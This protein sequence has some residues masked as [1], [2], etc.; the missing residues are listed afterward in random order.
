MS[1]DY[2]PHLL[3]SQ[4]LLRDLIENIDAF[5]I[6]RL[7][8]HAPVID[9]I[10]LEENPWGQEEVMGLKKWVE[11]V[12]HHG[13]ILE[14]MIRSGIPPKEDPLPT[15][16]GL[17][18][19]WKIIVTSKP[20]TV[21]VRM[22][23]GG[24]K[25]IQAGNK[26]SNSQRSG[27]STPTSVKDGGGQNG[28]MKTA[29]KEKEVWVDV[30]ADGG[31]EWIRIYSKK[32]SHLLAEF[33]EADSYINSDY[34]SD[35]EE[36]EEA[37]EDHLAGGKQVTGRPHSEASSN[38]LLDMARDLARAAS[39]V[40]RIPGAEMPR[41]T[42]RLTRIPETPLELYDGSPNQPSPSS[43]GGE[44]GEWPDSRIPETF[45][46]VRALGVN[47]LFGDLSDIPLSSPI[48]KGHPVPEQA[49]PSLKINLDITTLMGLCSDVLHHPLPADRREAARRSLRPVD[50]LLVS[51][52]GQVGSRGRDGT[53][54]GK[55]KG[56]KEDEREMGEEDE[57]L[58]GQS[59]N[60][61]E[62]FRCI[63]E[64]MERPFIEEFDTVLRTAWKDQER[65][66]RNHKSQ[67]PRPR[68]DLYGQDKQSLPEAISQLDIGKT[69]DHA[70]AN[71]TKTP[72]VEFWTTR[73]AAQYTYEALSSG[74][75]H[76][77]GAE[78]RRMRRM[79]GLEQGDFFE[80]SRYEGKA[81]V[82]EGF[83]LRIFDTER[84][85]PG[86]IIEDKTR[87]SEGSSD[88]RAQAGGREDGS[89][90]NGGE[91]DKTGFH[92]TLAAITQ[93]FLEQYYAS[94]AAN[95]ST[96]AAP[97]PNFLQPKKIPTPPVAKI[98]LPFPVVSLHSLHRGAREGMTTIM[99]G[100]ATLK[101]VWGQTRWRVRGWERGWYNL[102][103]EDDEDSHNE[104]AKGSQRRVW[105]KG[106]TAVMIFPYRVFGEGKRVRFE[107][108]DYSYPTTA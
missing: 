31:R 23:M 63:L 80:G 65:R 51:N 78:Q 71:Q 6:D 1:Q 48:F 83:K 106:P 64:E 9:R 105:E 35:T 95:S 20:P 59:Q 18:T 73:Q 89:I 101:E 74:P 53:G 57:E 41:L 40:D 42:I 46:R 60:S 11:G 3:K 87:L 79:L 30:V 45:D 77:D 22:S 26:Q 43:A 81:G 37:S 72:Q 10:K 90:E 50:H 54:R 103:W 70:G 67:T 52:S 44:G 36:E 24:D 19:Y 93:L 104:E 98:T 56:K 92:R 61:R 66:L 28:T 99:M 55:G 27:L 97:L 47:L 84:F 2:T 76:G 100:T 7:L 17:T 33:R 14:S 94:A 75:A 39:M 5:D 96:S 88:Q 13:R 58:R 102:D 34:D 108:G 107:K 82:F 12:H 15:V 4:E 86:S 49:I 8:Y 69:A 68:I 62:L 91:V 32:I 85:K 21:G 38:S 29:G 25:R 16:Q